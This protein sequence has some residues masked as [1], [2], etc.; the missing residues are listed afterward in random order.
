MHLVTDG[1]K[2]DSALLSADGDVQPIRADI[3][4][5]DGRVVMSLE[6]VVDEVERPDAHICIVAARNAK[7]LVNLH[8]VDRTTVH[9]VDHL[10]RCH[11]FRR[12][13]P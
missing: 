6:E 1:E 2:A 13:V 11:A 12:H 8:G 4:R 10:Q 9:F 7:A 3:Q 5:R